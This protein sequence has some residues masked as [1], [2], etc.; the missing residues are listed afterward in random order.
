M[1]ASWVSPVKHH[2]GHPPPV[3]SASMEMY[4]LPKMW[5]GKLHG[6][7]LTEASKSTQPTA[8]PNHPAFHLFFFKVCGWRGE[9]N[10]E[11]P[12]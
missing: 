9:K 4:Y 2:P 5:H 3:S 12:E 10:H 1:P 11:V 8:I 6:Y 7:C